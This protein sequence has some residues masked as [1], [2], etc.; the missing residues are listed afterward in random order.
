MRKWFSIIIALMFALVF[1]A[2]AA[3]ANG[4]I[5]ATVLHNGQPLQYA[6]IYLQSN[7]QLPPMEQY[8]RNAV[9]T[10]AASNVNG[11]VSISVPAG[12]YYVR[13]IRRVT[14]VSW[15]SPPFSGDYTWFYPGS[16][17]VTTNGVVNL[18]TVN[19][20]VYG[21]DVTI[22]GTVKGASG[23]V[24]AG[25]A[26]KATTAPCESGNWSYAHSFNEC[27]PARYPA[28]TD[29]SGN[30]TITLK[31]TGTYYVYASPNLN[32][33]N[34]SYPGGYPTCQTG[35][36]CEACGNYFYYNCPINV[37]GSVTGQ[38]IVVPGY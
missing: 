33:S 15:Q 29:A 1:S 12:T 21:Q 3:M 6:C 28:F 37:N 7:N 16:I 9:Y 13:I 27:G 14:S 30:Y 25:W 2:G 34:T 18:G 38:N 23:K 20:T 22:S 24:L 10:S 4:T 35:A 19:T 5:T 31:N 32:F 8:Y 17:T 11:Y 26:V 36:G